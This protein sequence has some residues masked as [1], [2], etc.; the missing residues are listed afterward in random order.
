MNILIPM[1]GKGTRFK[2]SGFKVPKPMIPIMNRPMIE[3]ALDSIKMIKIP[4]KI[5]FLAL[6]EDLSFG[7]RTI[8]EGRGIIIEVPEVTEGAVNTTLMASDYINNN[9]PILI[10]NCDQYLD[11]N[12]NHFLKSLNNNDGIITVFESSNPHHSYI[13]YTGSKI[14]KIEEKKVISNLAVGGIY[15]FKHGS[16]Y[17]KAANSQIRKNN[18]V[19]GEFYISPVFDELLNMNKTLTYFKLN[20]SEIHML[21]TP[22]EVEI[23]ERV[24]S[25]GTACLKS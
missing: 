20:N 7:L 14:I 5:I 9:D 4:H 6:K 22:E 13:K 24:K 15:F 1:A 3:W 21:G 11:W 16:Q 23:F 25:K 2:N 18:R 17:I 8:L 10:L 19:K 12:I